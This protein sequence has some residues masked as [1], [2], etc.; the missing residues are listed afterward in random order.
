M[1]T[2]GVDSLPGSNPYLPAL[3]AR[4]LSKTFGGVHAV[5]EVSFAVPRGSITGFLGPNG[6]G[7][8]TTLRMILGLVHPESGDAVVGGVPFAQ[9]D[10]PGRVVGA[11]L[12]DRGAHPRR[13]ARAHLRM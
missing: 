4:G 8:S 1:S 3:Q 12:D 6:S 10:D 13:T 11:V 5:A 7:K 2:H 9:L